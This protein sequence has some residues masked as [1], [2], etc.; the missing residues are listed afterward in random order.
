MSVV[1]FTDPDGNEWADWKS[2]KLL[3]VRLNQALG[4]LGFPVPDGTPES[5]LKCQNCADKETDFKRSMI[6]QKTLWEAFRLLAETR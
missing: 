2:Y 1:K 5:N 4:A 6:Q 3:E